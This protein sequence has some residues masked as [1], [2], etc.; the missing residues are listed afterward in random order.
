MNDGIRRLIE[1]MDRLR[2]PGGCPW[3]GEQTHES[4]VKHALEEAYELADAVETGSRR[5]LREELGDVLLQVVFHARIAQDHPSDPFDFDE[6]AGLVADKLVERHPHVF[7]DGVAGDSGEVHE[8]WER[9]KAESR[10][11]G[12]VLDGMPRDLPALARAQK[13]LQRAR[14]A[15]LEYQEPAGCGVGRRLLEVVARAEAEGRDAEGELRAV[16]RRLE[17]SIREAEGTRQAQVDRDSDSR[18]D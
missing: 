2:S 17:E 3:D 18:P 11:T 8:A 13:V 14:R 1:A 4:L 16:T 12:S 15:D 7:G 5:D 10:A 6:V 9:A